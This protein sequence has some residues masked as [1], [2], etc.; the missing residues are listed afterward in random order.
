MEKGRLQSPEMNAVAWEYRW[1]SLWSLTASLAWGCG[2]CFS[3]GE[4]ICLPDQQ[5]LGPEQLIKW[6]AAYNWLFQPQSAQK[7]SHP[8]YLSSAEKLQIPKNPE[9]SQAW[10]HRPLNL[11]LRR[12][13]Q[14]CYR[15]KPHIKGG[16]GFRMNESPISSTLNPYFLVN[17]T[18]LFE[19]LLFF[20][21]SRNTLEQWP[22]P[23]P[24]PVT[25]NP[26]VIEMDTALWSQQ[27][28]DKL[29][30]S[31]VRLDADIAGN[32]NDRK[33]LCPLG[34]WPEK[35]F[36]RCRQGGKLFQ[37]RKTNSTRVGAREGLDSSGELK[38][39]SGAGEGGRLGM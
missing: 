1:R 12:K 8:I 6:M 21:G 19:T 14:T 35:E 10:W 24:V 9:W 11:A 4:R 31:R 23:W 33:N 17:S 25:E 30:M 20:L 22:V 34:R 3:S 5:E 7:S 13:R 29:A 18:T 26:T 37:I 16:W 36:S 28:E 39:L 2:C 15:E 27:Q 32:E 38:E